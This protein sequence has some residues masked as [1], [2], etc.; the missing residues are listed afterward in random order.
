MFEKIIFNVAEPSTWPKYLINGLD[1]GATPNLA[2]HPEYGAGLTWVG[3]NGRDVSLYGNGVILY[4]NDEGAEVNAEFASAVDS[5]KIWAAG[6]ISNFTFINSKGGTS[7]AAFSW[8]DDEEVVE[9]PPL[10]DGFL[11]E[12]PIGGDEG[13]LIKEPG[14]SGKKITS[15][16]DMAQFLTVFNSEIIAYNEA[17]NEIESLLIESKEQFKKAQNV[18]TEFV[19]R[20]ANIDNTLAAINTRQTEKVAALE[21]ELD[22]EESKANEI[23]ES[24]QIKVAEV[25]S[26]NNAIDTNPIMGKLQTKVNMA[27]LDTRRVALKETMETV[28]VTMA[29]DVKVEKSKEIETAKSEISLVLETTNRR[30]KAL[31][32]EFLQNEAIIDVAVIEAEKTDGE[33]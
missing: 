29:R 28:G 31:N 20:K 22:E 23:K 25:N 16:S 9:A 5:E 13:F 21:A 11:G 19:N 32:P 33:G 4:L 15:A 26:R 1:T 14:F 7:N 3:V 6:Q 17:L 18:D 10:E 8:S 12:L 27:S 30:E 2:N 24:M